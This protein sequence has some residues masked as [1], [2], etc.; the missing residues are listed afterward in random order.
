MTAT[1]LGLD[2]P[3]KESLKYINHIKLPFNEQL[4]KLT[5]KDRIE[6]LGGHTQRSQIYLPV[7]SGR[8]SDVAEAVRSTS[9]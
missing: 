2:V 8:K 1:E 4:I 9:S 6:Q 5:R 7:A 3:T